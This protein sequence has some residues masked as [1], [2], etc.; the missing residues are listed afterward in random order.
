[1]MAAQTAIEPQRSICGSIGK[2][3]WLVIQTSR[4]AHTSTTSVEP[5]ACLQSRFQVQ[6]ADSDIGSNADD[7]VVVLAI[8]N[9]G[10]PYLLKKSCLPRMVKK[11]YSVLS[12]TSMLNIT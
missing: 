2:G 6:S 1:M 10:M 3:V 12:S 8:C 5:L 11:H 9:C 4:V 7:Q